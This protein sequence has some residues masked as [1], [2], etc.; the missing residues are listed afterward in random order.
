[1]SAAATWN[2]TNAPIH[3]KNKTSARPRNT[4][5]MKSATPPG[6]VAPGP[7]FQALLQSNFLWLHLAGYPHDPC[8]TRGCAKNYCSLIIP[9]NHT[10]NPPLSLGRFALMRFE[11]WAEK[12]FETVITISSPQPCGR[13]IS[14]L[15]MGR[16]SRSWEGPAP[17]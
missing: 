10:E 12:L 9:S 6:M 2:T 3:V 11:N 4:N 14:V 1:M 17:Q 7:V 8:N 13:C 15:L 16:S 5:L